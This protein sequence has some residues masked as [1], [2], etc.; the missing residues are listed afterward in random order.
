MRCSKLGFF[1]AAALLAGSAAQAAPSGEAAF[2][3]L[4]KEMVETDSSFAGGSC[5]AV[6]EKVATRLKAAG[7]ADKDLILFAPPEQPKAGGLVAVP[8]ATRA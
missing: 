7:F 8:A 5:T 2:R 6:A 1:V 4:Y 3:D